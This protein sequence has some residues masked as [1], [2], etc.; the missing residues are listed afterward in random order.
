LAAGA[1]FRNKALV[2]IPSVYGSRH[3]FVQG[4]SPAL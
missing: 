1:S 4:F 3:L 2:L